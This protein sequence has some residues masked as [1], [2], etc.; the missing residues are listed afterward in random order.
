MTLARARQCSAERAEVSALKEKLGLR[1]IVG[2]SAAVLSVLERL[3]LLARSGATLL[4]KGETGTGKEMFARAVHYLSDRAQRSFVPVNC[5]AIPTDLLE[6]ELFGHAAGAFTGAAGAREGLVTEAEGGTL[7]LD[8]VDALPP[9]AQVKVLRLL[10]EKEYRPLGSTRPLCADIRILAASNANLE[11]AIIDGR[12]RHDLYYRLDVLSVRLPALRERANDVLLLAE[13]FLQRFRDQYGKPEL[14]LTLGACE[15]LL[16]HD[17][18]GNVRE[19]ENVIERAV[20]LCRS[21]RID[22]D[23]VEILNDGSAGPLVGFRKA[24]AKV[25]SR[26]ERD[27]LERVLALHG[28]NITHAART[29]GKNRRALFELIRKHK[30]VVHA[31]ARGR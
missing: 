15:R 11:Q 6:N 4:V 21:S 27:Y 29:A 31:F 13:H 30:I 24:K 12:F 17:W 1:Q 22:L 7:F 23:H 2:Q 16:A 26:F 10:Q 5:G 28:G 20:I 18:P 19:L 9:A 3:P 8:E 14:E 25:I